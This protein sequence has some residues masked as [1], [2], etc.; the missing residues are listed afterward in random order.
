MGFRAEYGKLLEEIAEE[1]DEIALRYFRA[2]E[3][4]VERKKDGTAVT[5]A[6]RGMLLKPDKG[7]HR[8]K[9]ITAPGYGKLRLYHIPA[10]FLEADGDD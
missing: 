4:Q 10:R 8:A 7:S 5:Q 9:V 1:A 2:V 6:D 3:L